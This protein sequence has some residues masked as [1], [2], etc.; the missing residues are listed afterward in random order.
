MD[1]KNSMVLYIKYMVSLRCKTVVKTELSNLGL[2]FGDVESG[3]VQM[4]EEITDEQRKELRAKLYKSGM[5]LLD[6]EESV[7]IGQVITTIKKMIF[8]SDDIP[9]IVYADYLSEQLNFDYKEM[10]NVFEEV[11]GITIQQFIMLNRIE[12]VKE[13][14]LYDE[15]S[16]KEIANKL[17]FKSVPLLSSE[18]IKVTGLKVAFFKDLKQKRRFRPLKKKAK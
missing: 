10:S 17:N 3:V 14:L 18:F 4:E 7:M 9:K 11:K 2:L 13:L 5:E 1:N 12:K 16:L 8:S 15:L 6:D